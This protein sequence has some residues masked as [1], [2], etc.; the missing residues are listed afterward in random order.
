MS[1]LRR[2][3]KKQSVDIIF[4]MPIALRATNRVKRLRCQIV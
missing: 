4:D 2:Y 3:R 1:I